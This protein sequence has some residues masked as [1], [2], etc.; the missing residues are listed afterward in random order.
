MYREHA[1][2]AAVLV[3][4]RTITAV[5]TT[6]SPEPK[7]DAGTPTL[8]VA[9]A[10]GDPAGTTTLRHMLTQTGQVREIREWGATQFVEL[11]TGQDVPDVIL[12][13]LSEERET[14]FAFAQLALKLRPDTHIAACTADAHLNPD[15]LL[16][17]M[18]AGVRDFLQKPY[19]RIEIGAM[20]RRVYGERVK[21]SPN[22]SATGK[23]LAVLG[24]KG[25][26]GTSTVAVNLAVQMASMPGKTA[27][28]LDFSRPLGDISAL[29]DLK[30]RFQVRDA[31]ENYKRLDAALLNGLLTPHKGGLKVLAGAAG[32]EDWNYESFA[33][34]ERIVALA[35][36]AFDFVVMDMGSQYSMEW[37]TVLQGAEVLLVS[38]ADVAG[39]GK[40]NRHL[41][42][43]A[44]LRVSEGQVH[45]VIN[46]WHKHDETALETVEKEM[47]TPVFARLPNNFK[48][49]NEATVRGTTLGKGGDSLSGV[50]NEMTQKL[51]GGE[52]RSK[53]AKSR[54][55]QFFSL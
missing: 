14:D 25:G 2:P 38:E 31:L 23:L 43:L 54:I 8:T 36:E 33:A 30:A 19:D 51:G 3:E 13:N 52:V 41:R 49:V 27:V 21:I 29:L 35:Q 11:R 55:G 40:L 47:K 45:L 5:E 39:L 22:K 18:R 32:L 24:T 15:Y 42:A 28:L 6:N 37:Q 53:E 12:L 44:N 48:Q 1:S 16:R 7:Q 20:L 10:G 46:R 34:V 4:P 17:A 9:I 50:F 26:V